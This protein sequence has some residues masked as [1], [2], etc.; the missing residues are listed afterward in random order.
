MWSAFKIDLLKVPFLFQI[1]YSLAAKTDICI[2]HFSD[3]FFEKQPLC[4]VQV[5]KIFKKA[6]K[7]RL[8]ICE[9][10]YEMYQ[11]VSNKQA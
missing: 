11:I 2:E 6:F 5:I 8:K 3:K 9:P 4:K 1:S 10:K 7:T